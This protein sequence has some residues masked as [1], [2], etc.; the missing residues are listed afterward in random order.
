MTTS[1]AFV[2]PAVPV[3]Q[4]RQRHRVL[5]SHGR[6]FAQNYVPTKHPVNAFKASVQHAARE[7]YPGPPME[8]PIRL[9]LVFLFPRPKRLIWKSRAMERAW[10][11][12]KPDADNAAKAVKDALSKLLWRDDSQVCMVLIAKQYA[13]GDEQ[14][15]VDVTVEGIE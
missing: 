3:A 14:P 1:I 6:T 12:A 2:V 5:T 11:V 7:V 13:A 9:R 15:R 10:H 4:P 8:G